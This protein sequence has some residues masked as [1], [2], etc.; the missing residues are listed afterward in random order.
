MNAK[1]LCN[2]VYLIRQL[3][4]SLIQAF[5][6]QKT[7]VEPSLLTMIVTVFGWLFQIIAK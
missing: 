4:I 1:C 3:G 7:E 5:V 6:P 2:V